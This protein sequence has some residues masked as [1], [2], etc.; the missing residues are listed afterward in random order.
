MFITKS[1]V[2]IAGAAQVYA[3]TSTSS[4]LVAQVSPVF[5][6]SMTKPTGVVTEY[7][8]DQFDKTTPLSNERLKGYPSTWE[9]PP[10]NT[11]EV[12]AVYNSIDWSKV[13]KAPVRKQKSDG[14][15]VSTS[16]GPSDPY[17][18]WSSTN[19]KKPKVSYLPEDVYTCP[20][21]GDWGLNYDDG[22]FNK[23]DD[24]NAAKENPYAEPALYNFL[25]KTNQKASLFVSDLFR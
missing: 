11:A 7:N 3:A 22:P 10:T 25:A 20:N 16:D 24:E 14:S 17:C 13:P 21:Q 5:P 8:P 2:L 1:L 9:S 23:Y 19:C 15:W 6:S 18:W 4:G 12:K